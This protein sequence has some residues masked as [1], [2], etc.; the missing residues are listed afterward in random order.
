[1]I[2]FSDQISQDNWYLMLA[3]KFLVT[4]VIRY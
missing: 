1:M 4:Y 3:T 2:E